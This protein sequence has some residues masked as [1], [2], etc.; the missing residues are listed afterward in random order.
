MKHLFIRH[1]VTSQAYSD[2][3][4]AE[5]KKWFEEYAKCASENGLKLIFWGTPYGVPES[6]TIVLESDKSL[7]NFDKFSPAWGARMKKLAMKGYGVTATTT[8]VIAQ[9]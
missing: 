2:A 7:D 8:I 4:V 5:R 6:L 3:T 1:L 9:E